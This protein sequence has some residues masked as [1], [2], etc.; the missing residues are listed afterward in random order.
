MEM[1]GVNVSC[2]RHEVL[3]DFNWAV[4]LGER[5]L[6]TGPNGSGKSPLAALIVGDPIKACTNDNRIYGK[7]RCQGETKWTIKKRVGWMSPELQSVIDTTQTVLETVM[8]SP[9]CSSSKK[10]VGSKLCYGLNGLA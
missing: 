4:K 1:H 6:V 2:G 7:R 9:H 3:R 8:S 5:W 10:K